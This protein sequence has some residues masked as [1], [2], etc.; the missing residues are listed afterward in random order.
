MFAKTLCQIPGRVDHFHDH[1][2]FLIYRLLIR[3]FENIGQFL[4]SHSI[5]LALEIYLLLS[6]FYEFKGSLNFGKRLY[7]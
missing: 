3:N 6:I 5:V 2:S 4:G 7:M 1:F